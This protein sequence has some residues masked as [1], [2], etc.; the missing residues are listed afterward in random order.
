MKLTHRVPVNVSQNM[1][2][3]LTPEYLAEVE[4]STNRLAEAF[5]REQRA[6]AATER[7]LARAVLRREAAK[8][9]K[10]KVRAEKYLRRVNEAVEARRQELLKLARLMES[11][12]APSRN[13][14]NGGARHVSSAAHGV[15]DLLG[16]RPVRR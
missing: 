11:V 15:P 10:E 14:A 13:R 2:G 4:A 12:P 1:E 16:A 8:T 7:R 3:K 6:L 5:E 9:A